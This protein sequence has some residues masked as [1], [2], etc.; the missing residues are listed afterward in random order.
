MSISNARELSINIDE[1][2]Q[3]K[4]TNMESATPVNNLPIK[5]EA[6]ESTTNTGTMQLIESNRLPNN[7]PIDASSL[8]IHDTV[9]MSGMRPIAS[10]NKETA[11]IVSWIDNRPVFSSNFDDD[12]TNLGYG[13]RPI[14][15]N[16]G[17][18]FDEMLGY[19]D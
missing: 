13:G 10:N 12:Q 15:S 5:L 6:S 9:N 3:E 8:I 4:I 7:R 14:A 16:K 11:Q 17:N 19:L 2:N 18:D 1:T